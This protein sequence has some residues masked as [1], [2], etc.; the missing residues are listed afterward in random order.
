[1]TKAELF[2][3]AIIQIIEHEIKTYINPTDDDIAD[4]LLAA[5]IA[6][7]TSA[8]A[9]GVDAGRLLNALKTASKQI[10]KSEAEAMINSVNNTPIK[11]TKLN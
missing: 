10:P 8:E 1:M 5:G 6:V 11:E 4:T 9:L 7:V 2:A 3:T